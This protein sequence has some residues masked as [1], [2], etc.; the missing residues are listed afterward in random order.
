VDENLEQ[1]ENALNQAVLEYV[2]VN[3]TTIAGVV[4]VLEIVKIKFMD[5]AE[6]QAQKG[7]ADEES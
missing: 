5:F 7:R 6:Q 4:G 3:P 1:L 2:K